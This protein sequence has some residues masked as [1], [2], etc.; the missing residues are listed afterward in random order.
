MSSCDISDKHLEDNN[1][2]SEDIGK[3]AVMIYDGDCGFCLFWMKKMGPLDRKQV[4]YTTS[5]ASGALFPQVRETYD[6]AVVFVNEEGQWWEGAAAISASFEY[7]KKMGL[8]PQRT[9]F[10]LLGLSLTEL[11]ARRKQSTLL[12]KTHWFRQK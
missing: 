3:K 11:P 6:R 9:N 2:S 4:P 10:R 12:F 8:F 1:F 7:T 5:Q